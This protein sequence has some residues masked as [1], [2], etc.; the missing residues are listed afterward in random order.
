MTCALINLAATAGF[1]VAG[2]RERWV[3]DL[4][5]EAPLPAAGYPTPDRICQAKAGTRMFISHARYSSSFS[6]G[7]LKTIGS[8]LL[9]TP[10]IC[11]NVARIA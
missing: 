9:H 4:H 11:R 3:D 8:P 6:Q 7:M 2:L 10:R 1:L 5:D